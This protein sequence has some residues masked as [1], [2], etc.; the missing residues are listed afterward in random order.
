MNAQRADRAGVISLSCV[1]PCWNDAEA[2]NRLMP[3]LVGVLDASVPE[4]EIIVVDDGSTDAI[5]ELFR[6]WLHLPGFRALQ[7]SRN[8]GKE[9]ALAAGLR[10]ARGSVVVMLDADLQHS[11]ALIP[12]MIQH[13]RQGADMV[14]A[15]RMHRKDESFA[16]RWG[17][18]LFYGIINFSGRVEI[19]AGAGDFRLMDRV[20]VDA[21][22][23]LPERIRFM[24]GLYAW[25]GFQAVAMPYEPARRICGR[26]HFDALRLL[27]IS[28][29]GI[30]AFTNWPLRAVSFL[31]FLLAL[32][33]FFYGGYLCVD[34]FMNGHDVSGWTTIVVSLM[35]FM[36]VQLVSIGVLG[37]YIGRIFEEVKGRPLYIVKRELGQG[38][39][40]PAK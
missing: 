34:F 7:L 18:R 12:A 16:K 32:F 15:L 29:D 13:W 3:G 37:E 36:G 33:G 24:K 25:V 8:F 31:G 40:V 35:L 6:Y 30:T 10:A 9:A 5:D 20:V 14:Y 39:K 19:P 22:L 26:T 21:L 38:L 1:V 27:R 4:W 23:A 17:A 28:V 2:L 11:P